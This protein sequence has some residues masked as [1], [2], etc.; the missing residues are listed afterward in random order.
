MKRF[1][2][3]FESVEDAMQYGLHSVSEEFILDSVEKASPTEIEK[4]GSEI[5][6]GT[7]EYNYPAKKCIELDSVEMMTKAQ[8]L[9][10][11]NVV[12]VD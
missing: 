7:N 3:N 6:V 9:E 8:V 1:R 10:K 4:W 5:Y 12:V 11:F 2:T